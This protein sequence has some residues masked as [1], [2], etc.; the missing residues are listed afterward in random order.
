MAT[1]YIDADATPRGVKE[2]L[3]RAAERRGVSLVFVANSWMRVPAYGDIRFVQV[4]S[5]PDVADDW[6]AET[7]EAGDLVI[8]QDIPL[9]ARCVPKGC[10]V[11]QPSGRVLDEESV[12]EALALRDLKEELR[13]L[14]DMVGG[15]P[16]YGPKQ[17]QAFSN[18]LDRW[19]TRSAR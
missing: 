6:I 17:K 16:P 10:D 15:P 19:I 5:G 11:I 4:E 2:V 8:T 7:A 9:A 14:G 13:D 12:A 1:V 18:A 3:Y